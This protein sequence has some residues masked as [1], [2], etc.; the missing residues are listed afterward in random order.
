MDKEKID[1][2]KFIEEINEMNRQIRK[3]Y[4]EKHKDCTKKELTSQRRAC[5]C[6][7]NVKLYLY[8][9]HCRSK[10]HQKWLKKQEDQKEDEEIILND[11]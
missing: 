9:R 7:S 3:D 2:D 1:Y 10:K 5:D 8:P 11:C 4:Y 6:G